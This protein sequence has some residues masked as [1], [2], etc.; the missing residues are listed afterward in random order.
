MLAGCN[1]SLVEHKGRW[2]L[3]IEWNDLYTNAG[4]GEVSGIHDESDM[5]MDR[6]NEGSRG[7]KCDTE[8]GLGSTNDRAIS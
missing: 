5:P 8:L 4:G 7:A 2:T 1:T 3:S 6:I